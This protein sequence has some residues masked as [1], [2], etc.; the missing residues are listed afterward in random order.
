MYRTWLLGMYGYG[1]VLCGLLW[2]AAGIEVGTADTG[3]LWQEKASELSVEINRGLDIFIALAD[4][5]SPAVVNIS[6]VQKN[7]SHRQRFFRGFRSPRQERRPPGEDPFHEFFERFFGEVPPEAQQSLGSGFIVNANGLILTNNHVVEEAD[8]IRVILQDERA[9]EARVVGR[10]PKTDLALIKVQ[11][12]GPLPTV[13]LGDSDRLRIG[14]WVM[15]I[16]NPFGLS[17]TVTAGIVSAKGRVIGAGQ[18]D[19]FIQTDASINPGNSGG[20]LFNTQGEVVGINTAIVAGGA[21]IGFAIAVNLVKQLLPQMYHQG[22]VTRGWLGVV[23]QK[24]TP[25]LARSFR[26]DQPRGALVTEVFRDS[27]ADRGGLRQGDVITTFDGFEIADMNDLPRLV[28]KTQVGRTVEVEIRRQGETMTQTVKVVEMKDEL[29]SPTSDVALQLGMTVET[30]TA[31]KAESIGVDRKA[32][33]VVVEVDAGG[34]AAEAGVRQADIILEVNR[35]PIR[36]VHE[37]AN[38]VEQAADATVL[39]LIERGETTLYVALQR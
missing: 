28:A 27:P 33:V 39:L 2:F 24:V 29:P 26:L 38:I 11:A 19:D 13:P 20:P 3:R 1:A 25:D 22:R 6:T 32:G 8:K 14:E 16:G 9:L 35:Q 31:E 12:E 37:Y 30:L 21:G 7:E 5:L 4:R 36:H 18:Y 10:D 23:L 15:A 34:V 17:H